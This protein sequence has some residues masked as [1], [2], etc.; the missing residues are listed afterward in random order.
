MR[1]QL[2]TLAII[3]TLA[4]QGFSQSKIILPSSEYNRLKQEGKLKQGI[5]Y[6]SVDDGKPALL[7]GKSPGIQSKPKSMMGA[8][9]CSCLI[10]DVET[11]PAFSVVDFVGAT[12]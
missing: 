4:V 1:K 3:G 5:E 12:P 6:V 7:P 2:L 10:P 11:D 8:V 9:S